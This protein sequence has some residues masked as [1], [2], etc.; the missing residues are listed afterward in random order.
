MYAVIS[1]HD[2]RNTK[3]VKVYQRYRFLIHLN[4]YHLF[5]TVKSSVQFGIWYRFQ[6]Q[7]VLRTDEA[8]ASMLCSM[9]LWWEHEGRTLF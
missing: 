1:I 6:G 8:F 9:F 7:Q 5:Q 4:L 2:R 3:Y